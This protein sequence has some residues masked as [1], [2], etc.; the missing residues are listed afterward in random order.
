MGELPCWALVTSQSRPC[1][2]PPWCWW[3]P[4]PCCVGAAGP[5]PPARGLPGLGRL[6]PGPAPDR[7]PA[8]PRG[9]AGGPGRRAGVGA[10]PPAPLLFYAPWCQHCRHAAAV[11]GAAREAGDGVAVGTVN[12]Q[13]PQ[14]HLALRPARLPGAALVDGEVERVRGDRMPPACAASWRQNN[15]PSQQR[16]TMLF[17]Y[18]VTVHP[19]VAAGAHGG[20]CAPGQPHPGPAARWR[21]WGF[22]F[23]RVYP[24]RTAPPRCAGAARGTS[25]WSWRPTRRSAVWRQG[26]RRH[27]RDRGHNMVYINADRGGAAPSLPPTTCATPL[28]AYRQYVI[29]RARASYR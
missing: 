29:L 22:R 27:V 24:T 5:G 18:D 19:D 16:M 15:V 2:A 20:L 25:R 9:G 7:G 17:Y 4:A 21:R 26:L 13:Q 3:C 14:A 28:A 8:R 6:A 12:P 1:S 10:A 23:V 11:R